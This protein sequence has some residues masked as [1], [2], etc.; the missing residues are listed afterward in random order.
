MLYCTFSGDKGILA[1]ASHVVPVPGCH[2][3]K[4]AQLRLAL[5][6]NIRLTAKARSY[7]QS[8]AERR[9]HRMLEE[10]ML[11]RLVGY[12]AI[13]TGRCSFFKQ[14]LMDLRAE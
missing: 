2:V 1:P 3:P 14:L 7:C 10:R 13:Q 12:L 5:P 9:Q 4:Q 8:C 6:F 11:S